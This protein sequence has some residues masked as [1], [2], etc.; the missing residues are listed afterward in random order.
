MPSLLFIDTLQSLAY[1]CCLWNIFFKILFTL[2][3]QPPMLQSMCIVKQTQTLYVHVS[4][5]SLGN[6]GKFPSKV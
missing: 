2:H 4:K 1:F 6:V 5:L 3:Q